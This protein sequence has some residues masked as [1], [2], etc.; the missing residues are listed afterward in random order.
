MSNDTKRSYPINVLFYSDFARHGAFAARAQISA[1][2]AAIKG[3]ARQA[4]LTRLG[5]CRG[6]GDVPLLLRHLIAVR[7]IDLAHAPHHLALLVQ[8]DTRDIRKEHV[9]GA[10]SAQVGAFG[11]I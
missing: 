10:P 6:G 1:T 2:H 3:H 4:Q 8:T 7:W 11:T 5:S 9:P